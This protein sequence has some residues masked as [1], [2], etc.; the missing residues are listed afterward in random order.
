[1]AAML[2]TREELDPK[3]LDSLSA[4][5]LRDLA[6]TLFNELRFKQALID[7]L[8]HEMRVLKRLRFQA[9]SEHFTADQAQL[10]EEDTE[11]DSQALA[12]QIDAL[13]PQS[14]E[15]TLERA[16]RGVA[17]RR[18]LPPEFPRQEIHHEPSSTECSCGCAMQRIGEDV[19]EKLHYTPGVFSVERHIR[20]K[21]V[22]R[23]CEKLIQAPVPAHVID[24]GLPTTGLLAQVIVSKYIDHLPLHRQEYVFTRAGYPIARSTMAQWVGEIGQQ[25]QPLVDAM[26]QWLLS[27]PVLHADETPV[28][29][30]APGK[31]K[32]QRAYLWG[33][34][35]TIYDQFPAVVF[36]FADSRSGKHAGRFLGVDEQTPK[37]RQWQGHLVVDDFSGYK[38]LFTQGVKEAG[39]LAHARRKFFELWASHKSAVG[40]RALN[41]F[42]DLYKAEEGLIGVE[43]AEARRRWRQTHA[44]PVAET[45][46]QW[47][48]AQRAAVPNGSATARAI[49]YSLKRWQALFRYLD[50]G[51]L[52]PDNNR[53]E[54]LIRPIAIG[55]SNWLFAGS[56]RAGERAAAIMS[57]LHTARL[58]GHEPYA[59]L[60]DVLERLP[61]HPA[62][63]IQELLPY[64]W[65]PAS[66]RPQ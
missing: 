1:M 26:R 59:Y 51:D 42:K 47:L 18:A 9:K 6:S 48:V 38:H 15:P 5:Q 65:Q 36:D 31:G 57:L 50:D 53:V 24:K 55:R 21:W 44:K 64:H 61:T 49:D 22:C 11:A 30:L 39:C 23:A 19:S 66:A 56:L 4:T 35:S 7:K 13:T 28:A 16:D 29:M 52:P 27:R 10:F 2:A 8:T 60:K 34:C 32:T 25:L 58:N 54:N 33:Y 17:K 12:V 43:K 62:S 37:D 46:R 20:G 63:R 3:A 45:L 40:E 41:Y 14:D